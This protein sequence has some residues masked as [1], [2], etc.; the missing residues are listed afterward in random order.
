[1]SATLDNPAAV[2]ARLNDI[3]DD[4]ARIQNTLEMA[5]LDWYRAK[6]DREKARAVAF[7]SCEEG[8]I[9]YRQAVADRDTALDGKNEEALYESLKAV[10]RV[11]ETRA[12]I[13]QS[14]LRAQSRI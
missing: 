5:A 2:I 11:L 1:M 12:S 4:L 8:S 14:I 10:S 6:R 13:G 3:E 7:L 9:A